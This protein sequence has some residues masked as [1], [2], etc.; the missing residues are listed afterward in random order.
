M[1]CVHA[2]ML[3]SNLVMAHFLCLISCSGGV[4]PLMLCHKVSNTIHLID[5]MSLKF[6]EI[7]YECR[8]CTLADHSYLHLLS[9]DTY[10]RN[11][12]RSVMTSRQLTEYVV[13]NV[14]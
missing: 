14:E 2:M 4:S 6:V 9:A 13:L 5:P 12:F 10:W 11:P 8:A 3:Q 7:S 1:R